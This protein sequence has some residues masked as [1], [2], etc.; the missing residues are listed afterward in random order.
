VIAA[1]LAQEII[2]RRKKELAGRINHYQRK[3]SILSDIGEC[4]RQMVYS[5]LDWDKKPLHDEE[6]QARFDIGNLFE[7]EI[8]RDLL[9]LGFSV[10]HAQMPVEILGRGGVKIATGKIDGFIQYEGK[11][12]PIEIKSMNPNVFNSINSVEDFN[13]KP[14]TRKYLRQLQLYLFGNNCEEGLFICTD[15][16]G[17]WKL[18]PL[19]LDLGECEALLQRLE[20]VYA[21]IQSKTYPDR[22]TYDQSLCGKCPFSV[23]CLADIIN[24]PADFIDN[25]ALEADLDRHEELKPMAS[26]FDALHDK[27][28]GTFKGIE[29]AVVG[30]KYLIQMIPSQRTTYELP[31]EIEKEIDDLKKSHAVKVPCTRLVIEKL[32]GPK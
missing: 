29:K 24:K 5:V 9:G 18:F 19:Y 20:R 16:L 27:I 13:K 26:E 12:I 32:G 1:A 3:N 7:R 2:D 4:E 8:V 23:I 30:T 28:K 15:C 6:L 11:K 14:W 17:H 22:I 21:A 25:P 31:P 10:N